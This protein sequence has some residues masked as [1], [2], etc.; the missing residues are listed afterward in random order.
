MFLMM[1]NGMFRIQSDGLLTCQEP[2]RPGEVH[3][4]VHR[5]SERSSRLLGGLCSRQGVLHPEL[6]RGELH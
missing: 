6:A 5:G 4:L 3:G 1:T 2:W